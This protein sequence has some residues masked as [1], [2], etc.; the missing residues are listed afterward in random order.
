LL[1]RSLPSAALYEIRRCGG[2][3]VERT[4][5]DETLEHASFVR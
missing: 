4:T 1:R 3:L 2:S 5:R